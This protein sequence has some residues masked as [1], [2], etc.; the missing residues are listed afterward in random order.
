MFLRGWVL[1]GGVRGMSE[2][3]AHLMTSCLGRVRRY[4]WIAAW[5]LAS[6]GWSYCWTY[7]HGVDLRCDHP[8]SHG[9]A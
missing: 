6:K 2:S 3:C 7:K 1:E 8:P 5:V 4:G 9:R